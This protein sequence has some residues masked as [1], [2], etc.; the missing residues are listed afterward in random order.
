MLSD[1]RH[2][3]NSQKILRRDANGAKFKAHM[4]RD[5]V[6]LLIMI[7]SMLIADSEQDVCSIVR[8]SQDAV[9]DD[10]LDQILDKYD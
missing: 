2:L 8:G 9:D 3:T 10:K 7:I 1:K 6:F 4:V 5:V